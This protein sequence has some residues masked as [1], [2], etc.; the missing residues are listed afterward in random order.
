MGHI[1]SG[2]GLQPSASKVAAIKEAPKPS[3]LSELKSFLGLVNYYAKFLPNSATLLAP[4]YKLLRNSESWRWNKEQQVA[5]EHIKD[6]LTAP[7]LL[8]H[9]DD[10]KPLMLSCDAS[11]HG[12]GAVLS[13]VMDNQSDKPIAYASRSL[14]TA[15][16]RY[17]QLDKEALAILFGVSKFHHYLYGRHFIIYSDHKPLMHIFNQSKTVPVM[18][19]ARLQRWALTL[20]SYHYT[21]KYQKGSHMGNA[22]ALSRLPLPDCP[23]TVPVPPETI[24]L[25]EQLASVPLTAT[26]IRTMTA[27]DPVLAKVKQYTQNGWPAK[28]TDEQLQPYSSK[29]DELSLED[30][31]LLWGSRVVVPPQARH[32]VI[33]EAHGAHIGIARM[34][35]LTRQFVWWP[36]IDS[37]LETKVRNCNMCQKFRSEPPQAVLHPWEWPKQ[38]WVRVHA[39]FAG[40]FLG[41]M[42]LILID[43]HSKWIEVHITT[44]TTSSITIEKMRSTFATFGIPEV[45]V[46]DNGSN[47]TSSE[48]EEFLKSN[49][50]RHIKTA[51]YHPASNGLAE[52]AVQTFKAGMKK[53]T[54]GTLETRVA[55]FLFT[56]RIT[57]QTTTG[58]SPSELLFGHRLRCHLDFLRPSID[59]K[60]RQNQCRQKELHDFH[61]R[62]RVLVEGDSVLVKNFSAGEPWI[63]GVIYSKTGPSSFTVD[64]TDGR[65]VRRHLDQLRKN[66]AV[67]VANES[68]ITGTNDDLSIPMS[69]PS[70]VES[71]PSDDSSEDS[72]LRRSTRTRHPPQRFTFDS[73]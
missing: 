64:L 20:N 28:V 70:T 21:I 17:S 61:A 26:Q 46:T 13:H 1:I 18:A 59:A 27:R 19:S 43:A 40:P 15:E 62:D 31:I 72:T 14:N 2:E 73:D 25:L 32:L 16:R 58:V 65:R 63:P 30:G 51:P 57:P 3:S 41:K 12:V 38:P 49:G 55:R 47:F 22:D 6:M 53:L 34:K 60:V 68:T 66:T 45:L 10:S 42:F 71:P 44:S 5:F 24:G 39:D 36:K 37:D 7:T 50:I 52:R 11:P 67:T 54:S 69:N 33:E 8:V 29:R 48:F 9:F 56:Y 35:S 23:T 4:L